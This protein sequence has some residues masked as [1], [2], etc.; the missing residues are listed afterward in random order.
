MSYPCFCCGK[1]TKGKT[2]HYVVTLDGC[3]WMSHAAWIAMCAEMKFDH[4]EPDTALDACGYS[5]RP[6]SFGSTCYR[7]KKSAAKH[8]VEVIASDGAKYLFLG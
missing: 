3:E 7:R 4:K 6:E 8:K 2:D 1:P 5:W